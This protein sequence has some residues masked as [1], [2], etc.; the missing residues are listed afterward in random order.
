M[1]VQPT[2]LPI[3]A[4]FASVMLDHQYCSK[5]KHNQTQQRDRH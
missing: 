4:M 3:P 2:E 5:N 1:R